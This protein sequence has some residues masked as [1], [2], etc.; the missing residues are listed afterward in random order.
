MG[1]VSIARWLSSAH[2]RAPILVASVLLI[3]L[4]AW[5][6]YLTDPVLQLDLLY[7]LPILGV[8]W[9]S[10]RRAAVGMALYAAAAGMVVAGLQAQGAAATW[11][12][13][14]THVC[15]FVAVGLLM[16]ALRRLLDEHRE[17]AGIDPLTRVLNRRAFRSALTL[18]LRRANRAGDVGTL[19]C[20]DI[21]GLKPINDRGGHAAGDAAIVGVAEAARRCARE[22][23][24]VA[25]L[26]GD[27]FAVYLPSA[28]G[29]EGRIFAERLLTHLRPPHHE[30][31]VS[32][33]IGLLTHGPDD[34]DV[35]ALLD[36]TDAVL[37]RAKQ[38]GGGVVRAVSGARS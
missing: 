14:A 22:T 37:Y 28:T 38:E 17:L 3:P 31:E 24:L 12:N 2:A 21:D 19:A 23:D 20:I 18:A 33:S 13:G 36:A 15:L 6:D 29:D 26:G 27:E 7:M 16:A 35:D 34:H 8:A 30:P 4:V 11:W 1:S 25:R 32:V 9:T 5:A 10:G